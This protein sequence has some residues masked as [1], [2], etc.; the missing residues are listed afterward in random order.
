MITALRVFAADLV[1]KV[2]VLLF[3]PR[4]VAR[5]MIDLGWLTPE[6]C[7]AFYRKWPE[8]RMRV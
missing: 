7:E 4:E 8:L 3:G 2:A 1:F 6:Q 5:S